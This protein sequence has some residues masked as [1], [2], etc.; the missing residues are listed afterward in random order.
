MV[1]A[2]VQLLSGLSAS[3]SMGCPVSNQTPDDDD[4]GLK[5]LSAAVHLLILQ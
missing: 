1:S 5:V 2:S 3:S 4:A